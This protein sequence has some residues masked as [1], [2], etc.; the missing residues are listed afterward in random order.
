MSFY[1]ATKGWPYRAAKIAGIPP[2]WGTVPG[3]ETDP[4]INR[5]IWQRQRASA[6]GKT[7]TL[8]ARAGKHRYGAELRPRAENRSESSLMLRCAQPDPSIE[9]GSEGGGRA[10][11]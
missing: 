1:N 10:T 6:H 4:L 7:S 2:S 9:R 3:A 8:A 11:A 5:S